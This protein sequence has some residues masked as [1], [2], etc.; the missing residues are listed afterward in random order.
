MLCVFNPLER[1]HTPREDLMS[2]AFLPLFG[3]TF[4]CIS[5]ILSNYIV[6]CLELL[7]KKIGNFPGH[8]NDDL[9]LNP[10]G[11][12]YIRQ[13]RHSIQVKIREHHWHIQLYHLEKS[14][15]AKR[16]ITVGHHIQV[17]IIVLAKKSGCK[18]SHVKEVIEIELYLDYV[19][20]EEVSCRAQVT[21]ASTSNP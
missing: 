16:R 1:E 3:P 7:F 9:P 2:V 15:V 18:G 5:R 13:T 4:N 11:R 20:R 19:N 14:A 17:H 8:I 12:V 6:K 10:S 21:D